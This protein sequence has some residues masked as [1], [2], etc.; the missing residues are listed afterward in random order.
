MKERIRSIGEDLISE[1]ASNVLAPQVTFPYNRGKTGDASPV[2]PIQ[3]LSL[4]NRLPFPERTISFWKP[5]AGNPM[6]K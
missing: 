4:R 6:A 3:G 5:W 1:Q 2:P